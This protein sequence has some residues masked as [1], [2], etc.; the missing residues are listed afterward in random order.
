MKK[1]LLTLIVSLALSVSAFAQYESHWPGF[2]Y[3]D[4]EDQGAFVAAIAINGHIITAEDAD[5]DA[6][7]V[8]FFV[9]EECRG[10][11]YYLYN[12]YVEEYGDPFPILDGVAVFYTYAEE[13]VSYKMYN[14]VTGDEYSNFELYQYSTGEAV[15]VLT[16]EE[17][18]EGWDDPEDP[19][20]LNFITGTPVTFTKHIVG[21]GDATNEAG[22]YLISAPFAGVKPVDVDGM[23][24]SFSGTPVNYDLFTFD[25]SEDLEWRNFKD[26]PEQ[27]NYEME[28]G[29]GY[30]YANAED[31]DLEFTGIPNNDDVTV[32]LLYLA[33][34]KC[35]GLN[36]IG[37]PFNEPAYLKSG[38]GEYVPASWLLVL[39][40]TSSDFTVAQS[41]EID[42]ATGVL[43]HTSEEEQVTFTTTAP[44]NSKGAA[45][46]ININ[47]GRGL[48]D[49]AVINFSEG[50]TMPKFMLDENHTHLY[51]PQ[52]GRDFAVVNSNAQ[53]SMPVNFKVEKTGTYTL[54]VNAENV[55]FGYLHLFD[56]ITG[57]DVDLLANPNYEFMGSVRD[58]E[59]RFTLMFN[60]TNDDIFAYQNGD[61]I[62]VNGNGTLQVFDVMGRFVT[63]M[64]VNGTKCF[65]A[66]PFSNA[67][68][69][70]RMIG[71]EVKTQK[72][73]VR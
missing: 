34:H 13:T 30:L 29:M 5:W 31:V 17:H 10:N 23:V 11:D 70:F 41:Q 63:S 56:N 66:E 9:G 6:L 40:P 32:T 43:V 4:F 39:D 15:T 20:I 47:E 54:S 35:A 67:V 8:A 3:H 69:V 73:V 1:L 22:Y 24:G 46:A 60:A 28:R 48:V 37:N 36:L 65:S 12:G 26:F 62:F 45:L 27:D 57:T 53:G 49:R 14:H 44:D 55:N 21:Y 42:P 50:R 52:D 51:I 71:N 64:Q 59:N 16:G 58:D 38:T 18:T 33:G 2:D 68:Y 19:L 25:Q 61:N 7:E 72:I